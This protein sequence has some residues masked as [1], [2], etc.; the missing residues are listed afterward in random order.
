MNVFLD[1]NI[2]LDLLLERAPWLA[3]AEAIAEFSARGIVRV[4]VSASMITDVFY[5]SR[6]LVGAEKA[7]EV[8]RACLDR[9]Q[10][11]SVSRELLNAAHGR[12][13]LDFEDD[14]QIECAIVARLEAI[15]TRDPKGFA[16]SPIP[17]I[18]PGEL[19]S[20]L[21]KGSDV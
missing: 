21:A 15:V 5:I 9:L 12:G 13:G 4:Y 14:V 2:V 17:A 6:K 8:V 16:H 3:E 10:I 19:L 18:T 20:R 7:K 11:V 1:T